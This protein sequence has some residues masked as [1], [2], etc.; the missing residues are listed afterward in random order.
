MFGQTMRD[1]RL[2]FL[3]VL[4]NQWA[5]EKGLVELRDDAQHNFLGAATPDPSNQGILEFMDP[6]AM[7]LAHYGTAI[8]V[9]SKFKA[10]WL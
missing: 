10:F 1:L 8:P 7:L 4:V 3:K 6:L 5:H 9:G 2:D